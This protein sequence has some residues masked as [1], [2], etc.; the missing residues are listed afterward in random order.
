M[1]NI[2]A[3]SDRIG[4]PPRGDAKLVKSLFSDAWTEHFVLQWNAN[5]SKHVFSDAGVVKF[6]CVDNVI[7]STKIAW[8]ENGTAEPATST[9]ELVSFHGTLPVW[10]KLLAG[11]LT[12]V[13]AVTRGQLRFVGPTRFILKYGYRFRHVVLI[14]QEL[15]TFWEE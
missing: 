6:V 5:P 15:G 4:G 1:G 9:P 7:R 14:A 3:S 13:H 2:L 8:D 11:K 12:P 10:Q